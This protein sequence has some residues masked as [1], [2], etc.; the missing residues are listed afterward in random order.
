MTKHQT[1]RGGVHTEVPHDSAIKHVTG[2]A[3]YC[4]DISEPVGTLH[5]YLGVSKIAHAKIKSVDYTQV[6]AAPGG[7]DGSRICLCV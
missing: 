2:A 6:L 5:A 7:V 3:D 1:I 4:D